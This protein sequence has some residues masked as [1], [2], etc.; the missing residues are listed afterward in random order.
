MGSTTTALGT[1][2]FANPVTV[3]KSMIFAIRG[4]DSEVE[5]LFN[6]VHPV[7]KFVGP[8]SQP[9]QRNATQR[10]GWAGVLS[11]QSKPSRSLLG[12]RSQSLFTCANQTRGCCCHVWLHAPSC[13]LR[14]TSPHT[15]HVTHPTSSRNN[16]SCRRW[17]STKWVE[18]AAGPPALGR[19]LAV[20]VGVASVQQGRCSLQ[21]VEEDGRQADIERYDEH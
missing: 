13:L 5:I 18:P 19:G 1:H 16:A 4:R 21:D 20:R 14:A 12:C 11:L 7:G 10:Y 9:T 6:Q 17:V 3:H 8:T 15:H 2:A